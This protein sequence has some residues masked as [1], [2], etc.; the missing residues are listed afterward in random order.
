M[1]L[2]VRKQAITSRLIRWQI[3]HLTSDPVPLVVGIAT[4]LRI[5]DPSLGKGHVRFLI[6]MKRVDASSRVSSGCSY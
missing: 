1:I 6:S 2:L 5:L 3:T 4:S